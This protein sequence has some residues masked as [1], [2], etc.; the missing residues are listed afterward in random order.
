MTLETLDQIC[1]QVIMDMGYIKYKQINTIF[2]TDR[3]PD[4]RQDSIGATYQ[5][6]LDG[7][8]WSREWVA[9]GATS[10]KLKAQ[11]PILL[12]QQSL[13]DIECIDDK[14]G[15]YTY[16][17][18]LI[19]K[20]GCDNCPKPAER[21]PHKVKANTLEMLRAFLNELYTYKLWEFERSPDPNTFEWVSKG[22]FE[23]MTN[24]PNSIPFVQSFEELRSFVEPD[25]LR[26]QDWGNVDD[27]RGYWTTIKFSFCES[28]PGSFNY[29][30]PA[31]KSLATNICPC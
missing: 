5:D 27:L 12:I 30:K 10:G 14:D 24:P 2:I 18:L 9:T 23:S 29:N 6:Y 13:I 17:F 20:V 25:P 1:I 31:I 11:F 16:D 15:I 19:D 21:V 22:R 8:F 28:V 26:F 4:L 3:M 7:K